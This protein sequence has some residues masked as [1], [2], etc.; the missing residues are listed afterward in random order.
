MRTKVDGGCSEV[1]GVALLEKRASMKSKYL[2]FDD[3]LLQSPRHLSSIAGLQ[4]LPSST[5]STVAMSLRPPPHSLDPHIPPPPPHVAPPPP[6]LDVVQQPST[7][8]FLLKWAFED[9]C[10]DH[11]K[12]QRKLRDPRLFLRATRSSRLGNVARLVSS[13]SA[14]RRRPVVLAA[15]GRRLQ[16]ALRCGRRRSRRGARLL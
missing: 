11:Q 16:V 6:S 3:T 15:D 10:L 8:A 14:G 9:S 1:D 7:S 4:Q 13:Q 5:S 12:L 2:T